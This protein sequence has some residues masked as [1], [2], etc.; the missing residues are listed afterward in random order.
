[1]FSVASVCLF[2]CVCVCVCQHDNCRTNKQKMMK[3]G[4]G[5]LY[6]NLDRVRIWGSLAPGAHP[7]MRRLATTLGKSAQI[8]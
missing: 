3:L 5:V 2:V 1:M 4:I 6:K 8:V 7:P